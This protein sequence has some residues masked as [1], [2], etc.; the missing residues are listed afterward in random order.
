MR[1][2]EEVVEEVTWCLTP[3]QPVRLYKGK[4]EEEVSK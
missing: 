2:E 4:E 1:R 3:S